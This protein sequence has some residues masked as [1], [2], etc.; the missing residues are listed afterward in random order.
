LGKLLAPLAIGLAAACQ[1]SSAPAAH[2]AAA[3]APKIGPPVPGAPPAARDATRAAE[4]SAGGGFNRALAY[5]AIVISLLSAGFSGHS[6]RSSHRRNKL[7]TQVKMLEQYWRV[8]DKRA[9]AFRE[10]ERAAWMEY[11]R[12]YNDLLWMEFQLWRRN[13][14]DAPMFCLWLTYARKVYRSRVDVGTD[15]IAMA[16]LWRE[17]VTPDVSSDAYFD[18]ATDDFVPFIESIYESDPATPVTVKGWKKPRPLS[19]NT[20]KASSS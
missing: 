5:V 9:A 1:T 13:L 2:R 17:L 12:S 19:T 14:I 18:R 10:R 8:M 7:D 4:A 6:A 16:D 15:R 11:F 3:Q 20:E